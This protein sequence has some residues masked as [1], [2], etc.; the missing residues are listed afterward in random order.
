MERL[1]EKYSM[2]SKLEY[3]RTVI[4]K[5]RMKMG[6]KDEKEDP[7]VIKEKDTKAKIIEIRNKLVKR[8]RNKLEHGENQSENVQDST[9][10]RRKV[11]QV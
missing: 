3:L 11:E 8:N 2:N 6:N 7:M 4:P 10:K 1:N 9:S 5:M